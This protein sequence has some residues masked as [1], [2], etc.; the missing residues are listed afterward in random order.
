MHTEGNVNKIVII[1]RNLDTNKES[2]TTPLPNRCSLGTRHVFC[3]RTKSAEN[4]KNQT[5]IEINDVVKG[6]NT[7]FVSGF[8]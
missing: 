8:S 4:L 5:K 3:V 7:Y 2:H 1:I 6:V